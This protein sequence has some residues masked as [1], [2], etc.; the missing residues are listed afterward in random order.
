MVHF[1]VSPGFV[2]IQDMNETHPKFQKACRLTVI[3]SSQNAVSHLRENIFG[4]LL[5]SAR[6]YMRP[7]IGVSRS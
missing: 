1:T 7:Q 3:R 6:V 2:H 5:T 4:L